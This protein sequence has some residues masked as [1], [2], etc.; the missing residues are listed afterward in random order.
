[1][2]AVDD[3]VALQTLCAEIQKQADFQIIRFQV[4]NCLCEMSIFGSSYRF[5]FNHDFILYQKI[6]AA[7][8]DFMPIVRNLHFQCAL[9]S[10]TLF[11]H[12]NTQGALIDDFLKAV[13][14]CGMDFHRCA[15]DFT[16]DIG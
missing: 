7:C 8:P 16:G 11:I 15:D 5:D 1:M 14:K 4:V 3:A 9:T 6:H 13:T 12:F 10:Q 2:L